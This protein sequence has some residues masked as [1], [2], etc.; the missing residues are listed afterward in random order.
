[1]P[2][3]KIGNLL[4]IELKNNIIQYET[5][6]ML[7]PSIRENFE[8][9]TSSIKNISKDFFIAALERGIS[10]ISKLINFLLFSKAE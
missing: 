6:P 8:A 3:N 9:E 2:N 5:G 10:R 1:M 4:S 7:H